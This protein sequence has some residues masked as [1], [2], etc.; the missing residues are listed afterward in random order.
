MK[1]S[2]WKI[3]ELPGLNA[4]NQAQLAEAGIHTTQELLRQGGTVAKRQRLSNQLHVHIQHIN[5]WM[6]LADL[7]CVPSVGCQY[8]GLLLHAGVSSTAQLAQMPLHRLH[9]QIRRLQVKTF[10]RADLCPDAGQVAEWIRQA[11]SLV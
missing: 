5:K 6:A 4:Q 7:S 8:C 1:S 3:Q 9:N 2:N 11:K 10:R